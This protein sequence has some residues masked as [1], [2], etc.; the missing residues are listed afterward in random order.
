[1]AKV[2]LVEDDQA[3]AE[4]LELALGALGHKLTLTGSGDEAL[5]ILLEQRN[6]TDV[7]LLDVMLPGSDGFEVCRQLRRHSMVPVI[8]LTARGDAVD[9]V[10]GLE[11]GADDY[12]V[13]PVEPRV[14]DARIKAVLRRGN[15]TR[16]A[17]PD[18]VIRI[19]HLRIDPVAMTV[20]SEDTPLPLTAT[21][22]RLLLE[23]AQRPGEVLTRRVLLER[24]WEYGYL[25]DSRIVDT[26]VARLRA[27]V[28]RDGTAPLIRTVRGVGYR[29]ERP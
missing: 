12:V 26:T 13:K 20:T 4:T 24:V 3:L 28:D 1:M 7:V 17:E 6:P 14:L 10:V 25:G 27:K 16:Q 18:P 19:G 2:L 15:L 9:V 21:E 23:F 8:M 11:G 22:M 5:R 29:L